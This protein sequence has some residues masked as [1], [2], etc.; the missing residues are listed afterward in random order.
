MSLLSPLINIC[1]LLAAILDFYKFQGDP[2]KINGGTMFLWIRNDFYYWK[3]LFAKNIKKIQ[4]IY[5]WSYTK[6]TE[7]DD[8]IFLEEFNILGS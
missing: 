3:T 4:R 1:A 6:T 7:N 8:Y 2:I 5:I